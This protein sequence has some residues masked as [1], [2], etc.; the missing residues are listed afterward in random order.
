[1]YGGWSEQLKVGMLGNGG[2]VAT[3]TVPMVSVTEVG[4]GRNELLAEITC[5]RGAGV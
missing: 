1:M 2:Y 5:L 4:D 3:A